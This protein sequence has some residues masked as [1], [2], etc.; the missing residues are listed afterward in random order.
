MKLIDVIKT[1]EDQY[2]GL[3][4]KDVLRGNTPIYF[5]AIMNA[6]G[7]EKEREKIL[8]SKVAE[9]VGADS[10]D[11]YVDLTLTCRRIGD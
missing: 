11:K 2:K 9:L 5:H 7:K 6:P 4:V 1:I 3:E 10:D 8:S